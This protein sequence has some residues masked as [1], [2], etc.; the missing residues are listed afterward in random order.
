MKKWL[1]LLLVLLPCMA[2]AQG[3]VQPKREFRGAWIQIINGQFQGMGRNELQA[4]L[5]R[6]LDKLQACG[7][8]TVIF[9]VRGEADAFYRSSYEPWSRFLT[10]VQGQAPAPLWDPLEWMVREAHKRGMELHAWINPYRAKTKGTKTLAPTH[11]Y[12][13]HPERFFSYDGLLLFDPGLQENRD[14]IC[15]IVS[16]IVSRYDVDGIHIDDYFYPYPVAGQEIPDEATFKAHSNGITDK[17]D[18][19]RYNVNL[20]VCRLYETIHEIKPWVKFGVAPF[21]IYHNEGTG[22]V[23]GSKT[24]GLQNYDDLYADVLYWIEQ[25]WV[26]YS[27]PQLYWEIGHKTA[28][29][30][31]LVKWWSRHASKR[32]LVIGQDVERTVRALDR[33]NPKINQLPAKFNL[34]RSLPGVQGSCLWYS[35]AV[36]ANTGNFATALTK[37]Y[38]RY[39]ALQPAMPFLS[40]LAPGKVRG[41]RVVTMDDGRRVLCW[42]PGKSKKRNW[43]TD[44]AAYAVYRFAKGAKADIGNPA[45]IV[46]VTRQP[47]WKLPAGDGNK[48]TYVVTPLN[49]IQNEGK[50][51]KKKVSL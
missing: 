51:A 38:H 30:E 12:S 31:T 5:T 23:P 43:E 33:D 44:A 29:Y 14:Y 18:W 7:V 22:F 34:Q 13:L 27:V 32:P 21:G 46:A 28:D 4:N 50:A 10:G 11:P 40:E 37:R 3:S 1:F 16:D 42:K 8:N 9:Q 6:Q 47:F 39:P 17:A 19:R 41:L 25:G 20:L 26:D 36:V 2:M 15:M 35:A 24:R 45:A 49:R 48:Y